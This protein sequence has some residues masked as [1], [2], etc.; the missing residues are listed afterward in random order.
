[1][2][3]LVGVDRKWIEVDRVVT[4]MEWKGKEHVIENDV[5]KFFSLLFSLF[6]VMLV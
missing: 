6:V 5:V 4:K 1:M 3:R 2:L